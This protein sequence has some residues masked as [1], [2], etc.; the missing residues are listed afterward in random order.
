MLSRNCKVNPIGTR[1]SSHSGVS[2]AYTHKIHSG[3]SRVLP[4]KRQTSKSPG[5]FPPGLFDPSIDRI[6][7]EVTLSAQE[8]TDRV[9][10]L[11]LV[12][13]CGLGEGGNCRVRSRNRARV[14]LVQT[15]PVDV[16][17]ERQILDG[18]PDRVD[19]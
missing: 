1:L 7:L 11:Q 2:L 16:R 3:S 8:R 15:R 17:S 19:T 12:H 10:V 9:L 13:S 14:L 18:G 6:L 4:R 5:S